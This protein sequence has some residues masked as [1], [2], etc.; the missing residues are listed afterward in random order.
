[1]ADIFLPPSCF[2]MTGLRFLIPFVDQIAYVHTLKEVA[3]EI[4]NQVAI[5]QDNVQL[6]ID[7]VLYYKV[8][9]P[10]KAS[11]G[12]E[13]QDFAISQIAMTTMRSEIG[14][15]DLDKTFKERDMLNHNIVVA[16]N[17]ASKEWGIEC[18]RYEIKD[19]TPPRNVL[20]SME[21]QVS[22]E[23][24]KR[25]KILESE[26]EMMHTAN[27]AE[28]KKR[29]AVL[30]SEADMIERVNRAKGEAESTLLLANASA[31]AI[32]RVGTAISSEGGADAV[33]MRIAENYIAAFSKLASTNNT[34]L[35]S[36]DVGDISKMVTQAMSI[37]GNMQGSPPLRTA[38]VPSGNR[39]AMAS[40]SAESEDALDVSAAATSIPP[41]L[42]H[43][44]DSSTLDI[45][46]DLEKEFVPQELQQEMEGKDSKDTLKKKKTKTTTNHK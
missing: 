36:S 17:G 38:H 5:T 9:D 22:A 32:G 16:I 21:L 34:M 31:S 39:A 14:K 12:V 40:Q 23:R 4:P 24:Q 44:A 30:A 3:L 28:G 2:A 45:W 11:Y 7:G 18:L 6:Y 25:A 46:A 20:T 13:E 41:L 15:L 37:Y 8:M 1:M 42:N 35:M 43:A 33:Q 29:A 27:I 26:G 19:I 10:Y